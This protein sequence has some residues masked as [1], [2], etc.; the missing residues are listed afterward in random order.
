MRRRHF[1]L[2]V[3]VLVLGMATLWTPAP[4]AA[5]G[6]ESQMAAEIAAQINAERAARGLSRLPV[7]GSYS[8]GAQRVAESNRER[9]CDACHSTTFPSGEVVYWNSGDPSGAATVWWMGSPGH[10]ALLMAP[11]AT[12]LGVGVACSGTE[13]QAVGWVETENPPA[14]VPASPV[15]T[16]R[17]SGS[18]CQ[19]VAAKTTPTTARPSPSST[20]PAAARDVSASDADSDRGE[21]AAAQA[22]RGG[23]RTT[24]TAAPGKRPRSTEEKAASPTRR[25]ASVPAGSRRAVINTGIAPAPEEV[26]ARQLGVE[27]TGRSASPTA[28]GGGLGDLTPAVLVAVF[29]GSLLA[30]WATRRRD[31][32]ALAG[33]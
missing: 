20:T 27:L 6:N 7:D 29:A 13:Y 16:S 11:D 32:E 1:P 28:A 19:G 26:L 10:R 8:A 5:A 31:R 9:S 4:A 3:A 33:R 12:R 14:S 18:R 15:V 30:G 21:T 24:T 23:R 22:P 25:R 2:A 17:T